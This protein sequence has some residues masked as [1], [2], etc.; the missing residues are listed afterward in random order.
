MV[1]LFFL[2]GAGCLLLGPGERGVESWIVFLFFGSTALIGVV[3]AM[4]RWEARVPG[5]SRTPLQEGLKVSALAGFTGALFAFGLW[6]PDLSPV[7]RVLM[8]VVGGVGL[9]AAGWLVL[10][11]LLGRAAPYRLVATREGIA[12]CSREGALLYP[13]SAILGC[14]LGEMAGNSCVT[15]EVDE[16]QEWTILRSLDPGRLLA[17]R[18]RA[19]ASNRRWVGAALFAQGEHLEVGPG[20]FHR[21]VDAVLSG[22]EGAVEGLPAASDID[23]AP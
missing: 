20:T 21:T 6:W 1:G 17:R 12:E 8:T 5:A 23:L 3:Q 16:A 19:H 7:L 13:W 22:V 14:G 4:E 10:N 15:L 18:R 9:G 11:R 2:L